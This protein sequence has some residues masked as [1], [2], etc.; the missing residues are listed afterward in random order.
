[1]LL[2]PRFAYLPR[3]SNMPDA[4]IKTLCDS[5]VSRLTNGTFSKT[6]TPRYAYAPDYDLDKVDGIYV[7]VIPMGTKRE[8]V[9]RNTIENEIVIGL[10]VL[11]RAISISEVSEMLYLVEEIIDYMCY[12][13]IDNVLWV[14]TENNMPYFVEPYI[15]EHLFMTSIDITFLQHKT[16]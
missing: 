2:E 4:A 10:K 11:K 6:I 1:M 12:L 16:I 8:S 14:K 3:K 13:N 9:S 7:D 5:I 15:Q